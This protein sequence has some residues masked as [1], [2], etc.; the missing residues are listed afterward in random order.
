MSRYQLLRDT[1]GLSLNDC[2]AKQNP[3]RIDFTEPSYLRRLDKAGRKSELVVRAVKARHGLRVLDCTA[4]LGRE[5]F[6]LAHLGCEVTMTER[7]PV[8]G[9]LLRDGLRRASESGLVETVSRISLLIKDA[10]LLLSEGPAT[11]DV[12]YLDP[13]FPEKRGSAAVG[14]EMQILQRFIGVDED[15][16]GLLAAALNHDA[17]VVL[18]RPSKGSWQSPCKPVHVFESRNACYE[19]FGA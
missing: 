10:R 1:S 18:K 3:L 8:M 7:S 14:G 12:I 13:M 6:L 4:G 16:A 11:F 17:R 2:Y 19:V 15:A 5:S 9:E